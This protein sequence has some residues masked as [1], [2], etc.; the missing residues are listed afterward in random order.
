MGIPFCRVEKG[1]LRENGGNFTP[2]KGFV[3]RGTYTK[4]P[5]ELPKGVC[6]IPMIVINDEPDFTP[7]NHL[8]Q[9]VEGAEAIPYYEVGSD[10]LPLSSM[11]AFVVYFENVG[12]TKNALQAN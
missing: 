11:T 3:L 5:A 9:Y 7:G 12:V 2:V 10:D 4:A 1:Q 6:A 8:L